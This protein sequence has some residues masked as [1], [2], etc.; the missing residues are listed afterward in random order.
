[1][2]EAE[3]H[4]VTMAGPDDV[5]KV[6]ELFENQTVDPAHVIGV[7]AQTEGDG[8]ARGYSALVL[9]N[10]FSE[11]LNISRQEIF[12][13]IPMLMI[14]GTAGLMCPH[15]TLFVN[16]PTAAKG[17]PG[18]KRMALAA[19]TTR[20]LKPEEY[21]RMAQVEEVAA[22]VKAT[23]KAAGIT[24]STDVHSVQLKTP[25]MTGARM[26][27]VTS[28]GKTVCD[29]NPVVA[30]GMSR[31]AAALGAAVALGELKI[32]DVREDAIGRNSSLY[33]EKGC[34]SAGSEQVGVRVVII[35]NVDGA[36]GTYIAGS[37]TMQH[38]LDVLGAHKALQSVGLRLFDGVVAAEDR[39]RIKAV[40]VKAGADSVS[41]I[42]GRRHTMK[43][44]FLSAFSGHQAKAVVHAIVSSLVGDTLVLANAGPEHQ[45]SP[46]RT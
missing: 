26:A 2:V 13:T 37:G 19:A 42:C 17:Q 43:S 16:K 11:R 41:D 7:I 36:P 3:V 18:V 32:A 15:F 9:Q 29:P 10:L 33:S 8:Y 1:M 46:V 14:G 5:S 27:D 20:A 44:D 25:S 35:G 34:A 31:G 23:M 40:F 39:K 4:T 28:R 22:T 30:S 21:G 12:D 45:G 24:D 6:A 38:Q